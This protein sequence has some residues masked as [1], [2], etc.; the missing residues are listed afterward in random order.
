M[1]VN[2][3]QGLLSMPNNFIPSIFLVHR[4]FFPL[5]LYHYELKSGQ[6]YIY[7]YLNI[8]KSEYMDTFFSLLLFR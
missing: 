7:L 1:G 4:G 5:T 3:N 2:L 6:L 8:I